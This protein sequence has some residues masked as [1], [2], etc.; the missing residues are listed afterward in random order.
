MYEKKY[1]KIY[2]FGKNGTKYRIIISYLIK[3]MNTKK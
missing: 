3:Y 2:D 1:E